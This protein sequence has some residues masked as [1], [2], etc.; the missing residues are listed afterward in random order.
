MRSRL[1]GIP[2]G[3]RILGVAALALVG[4][5]VAVFVTVAATAE[6]VARAI[7]GIAAVSE[8]SAAGAEEVSVATEEQS[9][10]VQE[11]AAGACALAAQ[12][13]ALQGVVGRFRLAEAGATRQASAPL[14]PRRRAT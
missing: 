2:L 10:G 7:E 3:A 11:M 4:L 1:G 14:A 13:E 8:D 6:R 5:S 9:A 12:S